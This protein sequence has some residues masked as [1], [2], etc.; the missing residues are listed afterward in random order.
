M[1][2]TMLTVAVLAAPLLVAGCGGSSASPGVAHLGSNTST[3]ADPGSGSSSSP[4]REESAS[5]QQKD[6]RVLADARALTG[7]PNSP[8]RAKAT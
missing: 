5:A 3:S 1:T 2:R 4:E 6:D 8:N 7:Y